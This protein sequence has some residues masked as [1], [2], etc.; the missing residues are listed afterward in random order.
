MKTKKDKLPDGFLVSG[1]NCG[2][3]KKAYDLG[4]VLFDDFYPCL[5]F[6]TKNSNVSYSV[7]FSRKNINNPIKAILVNS[8]NANCFSHKSGHKDTEV[9][10]EKMAANLGV[11]KKNI[12]FSSTGIIGKKLPK[13]K[14][15]QKMD[16]LTE[17][18]G[19]NPLEF[20]KSILT[21]D[22]K[23]K[24]ASETL[25]LGARKAKIIG[26]AKGAGM[27]KPNLATMLAFILTDVAFDQKKLKKKIKEIIDISFNSINI[28]AAESTNDCLF[29]ASSQ[30]IRLSKPDEEKFLKSLEKVLISLAKMI[31][32]DA[33]GATKFVQ[34]EIKGAKTKNEAKKIAHQ[35]AGYILFKCALYGSN[36]NYGRIVAALGQI[37]IKLKESDLKVDFSSLRKKNAVITVKL[38][39]GKHNCKV[40]T[41]DLSPDYVKINAQYS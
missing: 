40:Y 1:V 18:A 38:K 24:V 6:F 2:I 7:S 27:I 32:F 19:S 35:I 16:K 14:I 23:V 10:A 8:G 39:R 33:E 12:L 13:E 21:T 29:L 36:P 3:K 41:C 15:I 37:K 17:A 34:L 20:A 30:K 9:I 31:V 22:T 26:F 25:S 28:D 11:D 4:L 5:G